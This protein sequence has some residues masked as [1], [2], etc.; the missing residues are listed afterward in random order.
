MAPKNK[1]TIPASNTLRWDLMK[2][3]KFFFNLLISYIN[4][5]KFK[6]KQVVWLNAVVPRARHV[7]VVRT[8]CL[9]STDFATVEVGSRL[10]GIFLE[11]RS[12]LLSKSLVIFQGHTPGR[13]SLWGRQ[14]CLIVWQLGRWPRVRTCAE[15]RVALEMYPMLVLFRM[16]QIPG[17][18]N[19]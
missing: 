1:I 15:W 11:L 17:R 19:K 8:A 14:P 13:I 16:L 9:F 7:W 3:K 10:E 4:C 6:Y 2:K 18:R 12:L 5:S